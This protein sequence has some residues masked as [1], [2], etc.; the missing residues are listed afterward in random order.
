VKRNI[1]LLDLAALHAPLR[2]EILAEITRVVDSQRFIL[3]EDVQRLEAAI[4][5]YSGAKFAVACAS[6]SD[7]LYLALLAL[8]IGAGDRVLTTPYTFFAT[9]GEITHAGAAP[10]F[11][12][13]DPLTYNLDPAAAAGVLE[14]TAGIKAIIPVH[15]FGGCADMDAFADLGR[16][17]GCA[18]IE[19][20]AQAIGA[21]Y[22]GRR[23]LSMGDIGCL[24]FFPTK[25]LGAFGDGGMLTTNDEHLARKLAS[26]RLHGSTNKYYHDQVGINSRLDTLQAAVLRVKLRHLDAWT[27]GRRRNAA[28]Y[29]RLLGGCGLPIRLPAEADY[30]TRHIYNQFVIRAAAR[31]RL[32][33]FLRENG[34]ATEIYYPLPL[35][36]QVC[37]RNLGYPEGSFPHSEAAA[38]QTLA[39]PIHSALAEEDIA[40]T[41]GLIQEFYRENPDLQASS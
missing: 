14:S 5:E 20:G 21:T 28:L 39:L 2:D 6:G 17:H 7:A 15:L 1:P 10:V 11:A 40:Y 23:A 29:R 25:N 36:M 3:G 9:A 34:V 26:L 37:Y 41:A 8:G 19:D 13:I 27:E 35:H 18:L 30:Q 33:D 31:G 4:A 32:K 24:S 38:R 12:D 22:R 16:R